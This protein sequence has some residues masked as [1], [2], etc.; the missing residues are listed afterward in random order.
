MKPFSLDFRERI[1]AAY[2]AGGVSFAEIGRR[3]SIS[4][5]VVGKFVRQQRELGTLAPQTHLRGRK[6]IVSGDKERE[7]REHLKK[8]PDATV[9]ERREALGVKCTEKALWETLRKL[10]W[11]YKKSRRERSSKTARTS[12]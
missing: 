10:G 2:E 1:V 3:F 11:R 12:R 7:L 6:R 9:L 5:R 8:Y 4:G